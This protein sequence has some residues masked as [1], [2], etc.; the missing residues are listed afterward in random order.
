M[1]GKSMFKGLTPERALR[2]A[3]G[4]LAAI[5]LAAKD[6]A[7][8]EARYAFWVAKLKAG[9]AAK[10]QPIKDHMADLENDLRNLCK[11]QHSAL[12]G[13]GDRRDL[14]NGS[15]LSRLSRHVVKAKCVTPELLESL[16]Y[17]EAVKV[18]KSVDWDLVSAWPVEKLTAIGTKRQEKQEY[19]YELPA[20]GEEEGDATE[21]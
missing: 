19:D 13:D 18:A 7:A 4:Q 21:R 17:G 9:H 15:L 8:I 3:E 2:L 6:L 1:S 5:A 12:F 11:A 10:A 16:G 20:K 14:D